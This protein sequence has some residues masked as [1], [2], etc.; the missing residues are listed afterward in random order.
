M[1]WGAVAINKHYVKQPA[2]GGTYKEALIGQPKY[3]NPL[4]AGGSDVDTDL[5]SLIYSGLLRY[6]GAGNPVS[7]LAQSVTSSADHLTYEVTLKPDLRWSDGEPLTARDVVFTVQSVQNPETNSPLI[8]AWQGI[9]VNQLS[10]LTVGF[11]L[12]EPF[13]PF[14]ASL[15]L[16]IIPEHIWGDI[17]P[18]QLRLAKYN[19]QPI[20]SGPWKFLKL[21]K[22][23][24]GRIQNYTLAQNTNYYQ[25]KPFLNELTFN[26]FDN[27]E[28]PV[29][30]LQSGNVDVLSFIPLSATEKLSN[31][32]F[33]FY[34]LRLS[35]Y[36]A[37]F[38][39]QESQPVLKDLALRQ[40]L[41][42]SFDKAQLVKT[43]LK[44]PTVILDGP[45]APGSPAFAPEVK[46]YPLDVTA[47]NELLDK[48]WNRVEPEEYFQ[49]RH[50]ILL[51]NY[52][53]EIAALKSSTSTDPGTVSS[54]LQGIEDEITAAV[55]AE[56]SPTQAFYRK[57]SQNRILSLTLT[58]TAAP[59]YQAIAELVAKAWEAIGVKT[60]IE[61]VDSDQLAKDAVRNRRYDV[62]LYSEILGGDPDLFAFWHS[63]Q[64]NYP[65][66]NLAQF[67]DRV[68]DKLLEQARSSGSDS[69][70][71]Q[72]LIKFQNL[73]ADELPAIF[74]YEPTYSLASRKTIKGVAFDKLLSEP[75]E[76]YSKLTNWYVKTKRH[77]Q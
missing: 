32:E 46:R 15:T 23:D 18:S 62:L 49:L 44:N 4:F 38:F 29:P 47:A 2:A 73:L 64:G 28:E 51:K 77:W 60:T 14:I 13:A 1:L 24:S 26:F 27:Y 75:S 66:L 48:N 5:T 59:E 30:E 53:E 58:T 7:N 11:T 37:L 19:L 31:R 50:N 39:N 69:E 68:G 72:L 52:D 70:R 33:N 22:D 40:A 16:G 65:G 67:S 42:K 17:A 25:K 55:R 61:E 10:D 63:S 21:S 41:A 12:K 34:S 8:S 76:R 57:D 74:L 45:I 35:Q 6:D 43:A 54:T 3:I 9:T 20:G 71:N 36:V 56:M